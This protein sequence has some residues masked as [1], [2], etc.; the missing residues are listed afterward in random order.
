M[1]SVSILV[2]FDPRYGSEENLIGKVTL[3][4]CSF[5]PEKARTITVRLLLFRFGSIFSHI[6]YLPLDPRLFMLQRL[7][8]AARMQMTKI[9]SFVCAVVINVSAL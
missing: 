8:H 9:L 2:T 1:I 6:Q 5:I 7:V 3:T 4:K